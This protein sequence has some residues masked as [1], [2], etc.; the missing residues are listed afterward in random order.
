MRNKSNAKQRKIEENRISSGKASQKRDG[1]AMEADFKAEVHKAAWSQQQE[2]WAESNEVKLR[3]WCRKLGLNSGTLRWKRYNYYEPQSKE[4]NQQVCYNHM[5][6]Q[7]K[8]N[9]YRQNNYK[10]TLKK[11]FP[12][13]TKRDIL[14]EMSNAKCISVPDASAVFWQVP[15]EK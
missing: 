2:H 6:L 5:F 3:V 4:K 15:L 13:P 10:N 8:K 12:L 14:G 9:L 1:A 7:E 11:H